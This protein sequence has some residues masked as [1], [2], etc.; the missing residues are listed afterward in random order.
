[1]TASTTYH[2]AVVRTL[3]VASTDTVLGQSANISA[4]RI[5]RAA[6]K[7]LADIP[8]AVNID[9]LVAVPTSG[10]PEVEA[11][12][13]ELLTEGAGTITLLSLGD[14]G[15][16][17]DIARESLTEVI[18]REMS[19]I[20]QGKAPSAKNLASI[21]SRIEALVVAGIDHLDSYLDKVEAM[22]ASVPAKATKGAK[23][24]GG[25]PARALE[26]VETIRAEGSLGYS[27]IKARGFYNRQILQAAEAG[28]IVKGVK[29]WIVESSE[30]ATSSSECKG[31]GE[32]LAEGQTFC[33]M[34]SVD[35][36]ID[37]DGAPVVASAPDFTAEALRSA[38][39]EARKSATDI[40]LPGGQIVRHDAGTYLLADNDGNVLHE[41]KSMN[42]LVNLAIA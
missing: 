42:A 9:G 27:A 35:D 1:M 29:G 6:R 24:S 38:L 19:K 34:C 28:L 2:F 36:S 18:E 31:C 8:A 41:A 22:E 15:L 12:E 17:G 40:V 16:V 30:D 7:L 4:G 5:K 11:I 10:L 26:L 37:H 20:D 13:R 33:A 23:G 25:V 39:R 32:R 3:T 14:S 21:R